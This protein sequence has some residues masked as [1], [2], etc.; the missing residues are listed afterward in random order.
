MKAAKP[1]RRTLTGLPAALATA[2]RKPRG[3][4]ELDLAGLGLTE[5]PEAISRLVTLQRLNLAGNRLTSLPST[6]RDLR[7][8]VVLDVSNN[9]LTSLEGVTWLPRLEVL[10]AHRNKLTSVPH[11]F[12]PP[13]LRE[14]YLGGNAVMG[15]ESTTHWTLPMMLGQLR[16]LQVLGLEAV[17]LVNEY[18]ALRGLRGLATLRISGPL[19]ASDA[20]ALQ[21]LLP[22]ADLQLVPSA[23]TMPVID[24]TVPARAKPMT[25]RRK[26]LSREQ[27]AAKARLLKL[28][29][30]SKVALS[31]I[32][33]VMRPSILLTTRA[34]HAADLA[35][36]ASRFGGDPDLAPGSSWPELDG[37]PMAFLAQIRLD[38]LTAH[39]ADRRLPTSG[40]LSFFARDLDW[41]HVRYEPDVSRLERRIPP[42]DLEEHDRIGPW[43]FTISGAVS[44][45]EPGTELAPDLAAYNTLYDRFVARTDGT[46]Q[47]LGYRTDPDDPRQ[48]SEDVLLLALDSDHRVGINFGDAG[49][50]YFY[51]DRD[52]LAARD[53]TSV[54]VTAGN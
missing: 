54:V 14:L 2:L 17:S 50:Q 29:A 23:R 15:S 6:F 9:Q 32:V 52:R 28:V 41:G 25:V 27:A 19:P 51:L 36:G 8:L 40:L 22:R 13:R 34:S 30:K 46:H 10:N 18:D 4:R 37:A 45:P 49:R 47:M 26:A 3:V 16:T 7:E 5:L 38:E 11:G 31:S 12:G 33:K 48:L 44:I 53:F 39:D 43:G 24:A 21:E 1:A 20:A 42:A 35:I